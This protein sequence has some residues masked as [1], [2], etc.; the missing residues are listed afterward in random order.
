MWIGVLVAAA[1]ALIAVIRVGNRSRFP[2]LQFYAKGREAGFGMREIRL[3]QIVAQRL[4]LEDPAALFWSRRILDRGIRAIVEQQRARE[5]EA[6]ERSVRFVSKL[7]G[8]RNRVEFNLP[9]Y[10]RGLQSTRSIG[11]GQRL[12]LTYPGGALYSS[13]VVENLRRHIAISYPQG[14]TLGPAATWRGR[15]VNVYF[16][17][18]ED[19]GY[20][21]EAKVI[22]DYFDRRDPVLH[23]SHSERLVRTQ[24]R[25]AIRR[26]VNAPGVLLPLRSLDGADETPPRGGGYRCRVLDI[27]EN[28]AALVVGGRASAGFAVKV[29]VRLIDYDIVLCGTVRDVSHRSKSNVTVLHVEAI[30]PSPIMRNRILCFVYGIFP[31]REGDVSGSHL[32]RPAD[33]SNGAD[34]PNSANDASTKDAKNLFTES[35]SSNEIRDQNEQ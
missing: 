19:A 2:L 1:V 27:S 20:Y 5:S 13:R 21:F 4:D 22:G 34:V 6:N 31:D 29:H 3:L 8:F 9:K 14:R 30:Q 16:L 33:G 25:T 7:L 24:K 35:E 11:A 28:G 12:K 17:R 23:L 15:I 10:R 18:Q 32:R 26:S